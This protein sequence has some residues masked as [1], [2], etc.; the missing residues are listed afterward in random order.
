MLGPLPMNERFK[1]Y[2]FVFI[3]LRSNKTWNPHI[4]DGRA[5]RL[6]NLPKFFG[7]QGLSHKF[8]LTDFD[9]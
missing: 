5:N 2:S 6:G 3:S 1:V 8:W 4:L 7:I 9:E